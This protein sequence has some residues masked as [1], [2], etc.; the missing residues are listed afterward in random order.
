MHFYPKDV[1]WR[2]VYK[3]PLFTHDATARTVRKK[4]R[5]AHWI[6]ATGETT[7]VSEDGGPRLMRSV[8][9]ARNEHYAAV[10][11]TQKPVSIIEPLIRYSCPPGGTVLDPFAGSGSTGVAA[12]MVGRNSIL[13]EGDAEHVEVM[14]FRINNDMPLFNEAI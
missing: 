11:P 12:R 4:G 9:Y 7:Y 8:M 5:P 1:K 3:E 6:G 14:S 10:H 13:I 2:E